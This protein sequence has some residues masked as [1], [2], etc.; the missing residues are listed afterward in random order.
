M[1][2]PAARVGDEVLQEGPHCHAPM[3][4]AAPVPTPAPHPPMP[5]PI[6]KGSPNVT[7]GGRPAARVGDQTEPCDIPAC[8]PRWARRD[9]EGIGDGDDQQDAG[10]AG[11]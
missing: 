7:I 4:P 5:L 3:H 9:C 10:G 1:G 2:E 8:A 6:I 11:G